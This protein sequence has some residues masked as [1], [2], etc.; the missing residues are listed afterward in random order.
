M[1]N[2]KTKLPSLSDLVE[3]NELT[4]KENALM[5]LLNQEP[6]NQ[7]LKKYRAYGSSTFRNS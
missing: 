1:N 2:E 5:V 3:G 4:A 6:P 7:W